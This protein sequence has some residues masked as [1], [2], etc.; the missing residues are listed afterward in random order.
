VSRQGTPWETWTAIVVSH[1]ADVLT[2]GLWVGDEPP[3]DLTDGA[4]VDYAVGGIAAHAQTHLQP[5]GD[6]NLAVQVKTLMLRTEGEVGTAELIAELQWAD[7]QG[8]GPAGDHVRRKRLETTELTG[9]HQF[10]L[11]GARGRYAAIRVGGY[12]RGQTW[13]LAGWGLG[14]IRT[15]V[16]R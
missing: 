13:T 1:T 10:P 14:L 2:L 4:W 7:R 16:G 15:G 8:A 12:S 3:T 9:L 6:P 5:Q 11:I